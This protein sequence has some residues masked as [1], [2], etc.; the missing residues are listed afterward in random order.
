MFRN[1]V[2]VPSSKAGCRLSTSSLWRW[3]WHR[4][5][6]RRPTTIWRRGNTQKNI[7]N[8]QITAKVWNL[9]FLFISHTTNVLL[10]KFLC[11]I[12]NAVFGSEGDTLYFWI[13]NAAKNRHCFATQSRYPFLRSKPPRF[14]QIISISSSMIKFSYTEK[15][16]V[17]W[18]MTPYSVVDRKRRFGETWC[19][20][21]F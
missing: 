16:I 8:Y 18:V 9:H 6:K 1:P 3:N 2:S 10:F 13:R 20:L 12:F 7:Y 19:L 21:P 11:N 17:F 5:P 14:Q 15:I 4:V